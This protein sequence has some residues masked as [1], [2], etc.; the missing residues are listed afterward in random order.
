V[1]VSMVEQSTRI[2]SST[3]VVSTP[4][5]ESRYTLRTCRPSGTIVKRNR[6]GAALV[7]WSASLDLQVVMRTDDSATS[8][9]FEQTRPFVGASA[10]KFRSARSSTSY[11]CSLAPSSSFFSRF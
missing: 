2:L 7:S 8:R 11:T 5:C 1:A 3:D 6:L 4:A 9:A 10:S